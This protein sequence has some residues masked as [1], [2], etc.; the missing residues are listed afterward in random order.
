MGN[1]QEVLDNVR[2]AFEY[3]VSFVS[4]YLTGKGFDMGCG[5]CP[6]M[7]S[8]DIIH[9]DVSP[10]PLAVQQ[11]GKERFVQYDCSL[12]WNFDYG[13]V[14]FIFSSHMVEDLP[15][16]EAIVDCIVAWSMYLKEGGYLV[17][18]LP[19][20]QGGRYWTVEE[21]GNPSHRVNVGKQFIEEIRME[22]YD[23]G[24]IRIVQM[25]TIPHDKSCSI[26]FV[27]EKIKV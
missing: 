22:L 19:D 9:F 11:V 16:K 23:R 4:K 17:L 14:D 26:D 15:T 1:I 20:M 7:T 10:Q 13:L 27:F 24:G 18:L 6:L 2:P 25:D 3:Q 8:D 12:F 21:G 5:N